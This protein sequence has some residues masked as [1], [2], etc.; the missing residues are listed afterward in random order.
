[1]PI[2]RLSENEIAIRIVPKI[3]RWPTANVAKTIAWDRLRD[4]V[5]ALRGLARAV[6][7]GCAA[8]E[9]DRDLAPGGIR[10]RRST[11]GEK[12]LAELTDMKL[13]KAAEEAVANDLALLEEKMVEMP[14]PPT[15][16]ADVMLGREIRDFVRSQKSPVDFV[17]KSVTDRAVLSAVLT[18]PAYLSGLTGA[19]WNA[20]RARAREGLYPEQT[21]MQQ[22]LAKAMEDVRAGVAA[23]KRAILDRCELREDS[24]GKFQPNRELSAAIG[25]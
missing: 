23:T 8:V 22:E 7:Q 25:E 13:V 19:E 16:F 17:M 21:K 11:I 24:E 2:R 1:M 4:S 20:V 9:E 5:D 12:A 18:A 15:N 3:L 10:R 6:D 14:K